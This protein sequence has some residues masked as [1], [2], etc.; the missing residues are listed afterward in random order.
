MEQWW[1]D[2]LMSNIEK[3]ITPSEFAKLNAQIKK[4]GSKRPYFL[5]FPNVT[6]TWRIGL[7][8]IS[9]LCYLNCHRDGE[10]YS[11]KRNFTLL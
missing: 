2:Y 8:W 4:K 9:R 6:V 7:W 3:H 1:A 11:Y 10:I 5:F